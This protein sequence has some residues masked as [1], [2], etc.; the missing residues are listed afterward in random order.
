MSIF[1]KKLT[2]N[3]FKALELLFLKMFILPIKYGKKDGYKAHDY[4]RDRFLKYDQ[5]MRAVG[6][7]GLS[8]ED[9]R[10]ERAKALEILDAIWPKIPMDLKHS[11]ILEIGCGNGF[12]TDYLS[13]RGANNYTGLDITDVLFPGLKQRFPQFV[14]IKKDIT[15]EP[16]GDRFDLVLMMDVIQHIVNKEKFG[17]AMQNIRASLQEKGVFIVAPITPS[18]KRYF[19]H[20]RS[21]PQESLGPFFPDADFS[22]EKIG[23][24]PKEDLLLIRKK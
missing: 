20:V 22:T 8:E 13:R 1:L 5:Q 11:K 18:S 4:W 2:R 3:P 12:Y 6:N 23:F 15:A 21:W 10:R 19:F 7:E 17:T 14:F 16:V 24:R 9:N